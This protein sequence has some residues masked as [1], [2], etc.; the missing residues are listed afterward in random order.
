MY[1]LGR[2]DEAVL[3]FGKACTYRTAHITRSLL[4]H[5]HRKG[6]QVF[7]APYSA[8]AQ[9]VYHQDDN[10]IVAI[11]GSA[12]ALAFNADK[13][14]IGFDWENKRVSF[15][16]KE[17][18]LAKLSMNQSQF[19]D[20]CLLAGLSLLSP[21][22]EIDTEATPKIPAARAVLAQCGFDGHAVCVRAKDEQYLTLFR[23]AKTA[24]RHMIICTGDGEDKQLDFE[25]CPNDT[26][27]FISTRLPEEIFYYHQ[28]GFIGQRVLNSRVRQEVFETPPLDGG[29]SQ[30]YKVSDSLQHPNT[31]Y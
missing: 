26:H 8:A 19:V 24:V 7:V 11:S 10:S 1:D 25:N 3:A 4:F 14:I 31:L 30:I 5:L 2:G 6:I 22:P 23:K 13:V 27:E 18:L 9:L 16:I 15:I 29:H 21:L 20:L 12:S 28:R 17:Q